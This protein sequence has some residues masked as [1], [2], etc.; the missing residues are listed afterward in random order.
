[1]ALEP[2][3]LGYFLLFLEVAIVREWCSMDLVGCR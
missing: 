2:S 1:L 3:V